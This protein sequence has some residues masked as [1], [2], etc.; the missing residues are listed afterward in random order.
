MRIWRVSA[1]LGSVALA[2]SLLSAQ[3]VLGR[4]ATHFNGK[5]V[6]P[7][8]TAP[9]GPV[10][11]ERV[12]S[13]VARTQSY[14]DTQGNFSFDLSDAQH[15]MPDASVNRPSA[16]G[17]G[18]AIATAVND[19]GLRASMAGY[20]S[21]LISLGG[22]RS[23]D[24]AN[25]GTIML[26]SISDTQGL[27]VSAASA[28]APPNARKA[29]EKGL[30]AVKKSKA[31]EAQTDFLKATSL[32]PRYA[33]AW[34]ELGRVYEQQDRLGEAREAYGKSIAA[35]SKF[36]KPY[37]RLYL[38]SMKEK[39]WDDVAETTERVMN[40]DLYD[41][42]AAAYYN[43]VANLERGKL[44]VAEGSARKGAA[45]GGDPKINY[46]LGVILATKRDFEGAAECLR[47]YLKS[48]AVTDREKVTKLLAEVEK[49][50]ELKK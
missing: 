29:F 14:T 2:A 17:G 33:S 20:R 3:G 26:H 12:C 32:Y 13:N 19:C 42:P 5:V 22:R 41:F 39:K 11:I 24:D 40:L 37:E 48:D 34:L 36:I 15:A 9:P 21:D 18:Q 1:M 35:D 38:L 4:A 16:G 25:V 49:Q 43:A 44:D 31:D 6:M 7:D 8:G 45:L 10:A 28:L 47:I 46:V 27:T 50:G 23:L 30:E